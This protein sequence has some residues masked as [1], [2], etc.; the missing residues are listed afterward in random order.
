M[1]TVTLNSRSDHE[2]FLHLK[3]P[4]ALPDAEIK[5]IIILQPTL[6][7]SADPTPTE[8]GWSPGFFERTAGAW[9]GELQREPQGEYEVREEL[10]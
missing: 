10:W 2:G 5:V 9:E 7:V 8:L 1:Q 4:A 6:P 3:I